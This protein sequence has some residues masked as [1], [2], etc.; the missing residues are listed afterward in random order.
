VILAEEREDEIVG[1]C[2]WMVHAE[3]SA[4]DDGNVGVHC[5]R[6]GVVSSAHCEEELI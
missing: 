3:E 2:C 1:G 4:N 6:V 5:L